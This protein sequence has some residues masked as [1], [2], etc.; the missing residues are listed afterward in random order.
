MQRAWAVSVEINHNLLLRG[1]S[2]IDK[3]DGLRTPIRHDQLGFIWTQ[4]DAQGSLTARETRDDLVRRWGKHI[5]DVNWRIRDVENLAGRIIDHLAD[6]DSSTRRTERIIGIT[7][8][9][10]RGASRS[11]HGYIRWSRRPGGADGIDFV[12]GTWHVAHLRD[13]CRAAANFHLNLRFFGIESVPF[14]HT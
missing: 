6:G 8:V 2:D 12:Q 3:G 9:Q 13:L 4:R 14:I 11:G 1:R 5:Y 7:A 10:C